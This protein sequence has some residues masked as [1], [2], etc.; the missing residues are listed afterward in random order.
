MDTQVKDC[1][2][3]ILAG[4]EN[5]RMPVRKGFI[6]V[7][8]KKIIEQ[9]LNILNNLFKEVFIITN[10]P[11]AYV[12]LETPLLGDLHD[13]R[14]PMTGILTAL[15]NSSNPWVF[16]SACDMP[17]LNTDLIHYLLLQRKGFDA[18]VPQSPPPQL[19]A[20]LP[21]GR[22]KAVPLAKGGS[23]RDYIEPLYACYSKRLIPA[24]ERAVV[25]DNRGIKDFLMNKKVKYVSY[26][27]VRKIDP[28]SKAFVNLNTPED[29]KH[30]L[31]THDI[32]K[33]N[34][35]TTGR[36]YVRHN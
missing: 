14:G 6:Q 12:H 20:C 35:K 8:G 15:V 23:R 16:V 19:T 1:T 28:S 9:N 26:R 30:F 34:R 31:K 36:Q 25:P 18:V 21:A 13:I 22:D 2:G 4:G 11:E 33:F 27:E 7:N 3:I 29:I 10:E 32:L 24:M 5:T 17:F